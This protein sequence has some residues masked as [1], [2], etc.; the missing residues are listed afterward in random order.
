[1]NKF[2]PGTTIA[3]GLNL[4][5][6]ACLITGLILPAGLLSLV[7]YFAAIKEVS[8]YT[9][10]YQFITVFVSAILT[11]IAIDLP[12]TGIPFISLTLIFAAAASIVRIMYFCKFAYTGRPW[13]E[14]LMLFISV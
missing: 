14:P 9:S 8:K 5:A 11:G 10:W 6:L 2:H 12:F 13:F 4:A 7:A 1:M 3:V